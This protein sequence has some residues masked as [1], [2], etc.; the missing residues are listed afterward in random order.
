MG[1]G[2]WLQLVALGPRP[3]AVAPRYGGPRTFQ[4]NPAAEALPA[5]IYLDVPSTRVAR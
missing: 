1:A 3:A 4:F 2:F 5:M